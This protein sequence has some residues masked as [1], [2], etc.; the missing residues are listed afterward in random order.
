[1][2]EAIIKTTMDPESA[3]MAFCELAGQMFAADKAAGKFDHIA[4]EIHDGQAFENGYAVGVT[5]AISKILLGEL[6]IGAIEEEH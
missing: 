2:D 6:E 1:M 5:A 4:P 3:A